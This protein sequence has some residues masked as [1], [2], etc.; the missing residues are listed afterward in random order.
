MNGNE[1]VFA[2]LGYVPSAVTMELGAESSNLGM[3]ST[4]SATNFIA[5]D[6]G[7]NPF[8]PIEGSFAKEFGGNIFSQQENF[9][10]QYDK[11]DPSTSYAVPYSYIELE[12]Y[13]A[14]P[15]FG[16][17]QISFDF[18]KIVFVLDI[19]DPSSSNAQIPPTF[20]DD[21][22]NLNQTTNLYDPS[23]TFARYIVSPTNHQWSISLG[24]QSATNGV[25]HFSYILM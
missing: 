3:P 18:V 4:G 16:T 17:P 22:L 12:G 8:M 19:P 10:F 25:L 6:I 15:Q 1:N 20:S 24:I 5:N 11:V 2:S 14:S 7:V 23:N 13:I 21:L 9:V